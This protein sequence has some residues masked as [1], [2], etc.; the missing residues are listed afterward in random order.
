M[1]AVVAEDSVSDP[2]CGQRHSRVV[3]Y[4][5]V[6]KPNPCF[7]F[8]SVD[9][10]ATSDSFGLLEPPVE[11]LELRLEALVATEEASYDLK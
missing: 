3:Q 6:L 10:L 1:C 2:L 8:D 11:S 9:C 7:V 4:F 5:A